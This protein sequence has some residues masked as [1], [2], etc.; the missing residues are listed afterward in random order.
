MRTRPEVPLGHQA[1]LL[2]AMNGLF[3][4]AV[5]LSNTF[6]N[7]YLWKIKNDFSLIG[8]YNLMMYV[9]MPVVFYLGGIMVKRV[10]RVMSIRLGVAFMALF[11]L[12]VLLLGKAAADY[13]IVLGIVLG[14]GQ[15]LYWLGYN[16]MYF[17]ITGPEN[18]DRF[19]GVNGFLGSGAGMAAPVLAGWIISRMENFTGYKII[20]SVSLGIF[21]AAVVTSFFIVSRKAE[22][23]YD[24]KTTWKDTISEH[25]HWHWVSL[26]VIFQGAREGLITF[27]LG[28]LIYIVT[29]SEMVL[30]AYTFAIS[31]FGLISF[32]YVGKWMSKEKREKALLIGALMMTLTVLPLFL[33]FNVYTLFIVGIGGAFFYP[34]YGIALTSSTFD[35]IGESKEKAVRRVEYVVFREWALNIGRVGG[36]LF[37]LWV[38]LKNPSH[39]MLAFLLLVVNAVQLMSWVF[40]RHVYSHQ[41]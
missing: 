16:V 35:V 2:L 11:Y 1:K 34:F 8:L 36:L 29:T 6:V 24:L 31:L 9:T 40:M 17:E 38:V 21:L 33:K 26:A 14:I 27:F 5:A 10:D 4:V 15:G 25:S 30:G 22:G 12:V 28:L 37:F 20:F 32:Y 23:N 41:R 39:N 13:I 18:R 19:N 7:V 3:L